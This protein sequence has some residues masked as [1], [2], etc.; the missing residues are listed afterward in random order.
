[1]KTSSEFAT[2]DRPS[3]R[4]VPSGVHRI[5]LSA[6][7]NDRD[8]AVQHAHAAMIS[9]PAA[10]SELDVA[11]SMSQASHTH[12]GMRPL[13]LFERALGRVANSPRWRA[14]ASTNV[15]VAV[16]VAALV[17]RW[18]VHSAWGCALVSLSPL[19]LMASR[20][21]RTARALYAGMLWLA[22][23]WM[24]LVHSV[25][26]AEGNLQQLL[27][28]CVLAV[29]MLSLRHNFRSMQELSR[30]DPLTGL[31]NRRGFEEYGGAELRR[32]ARYGRPITFALLD[33]DRFKQ[34]NDRYGHAT[35][36][37][38]L[39]AVAAQ[40]RELRNSDLAVR[41][42]GDEFGL[43]MPETDAAGAELL[44]ARLMQRIDESVQTQGWPVSVSVGLAESE[45]PAALRTQPA[46]QL[47]DELVSAADTQMY[48]VKN[49]KRARAQ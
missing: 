33:V 25:P 17:A 28:L 43:L 11:S 37:R 39:Q 35:G 18:F 24:Q 16:A 4:F 49:S 7:K 27:S 26:A 46:A 2:S 14:I 5:D 30:R 29:I 1:M 15:V 23:S 31:L 34:I 20:E 36:D 6:G 47:I 40:L 13:A 22:L 44:V 41:L 48:E 21:R 3:Q 8:V 10:D 38:V 42:G 32:A 45:R 19:L 12:S 9:A